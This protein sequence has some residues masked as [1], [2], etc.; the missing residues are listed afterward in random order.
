MSRKRKFE[1]GMAVTNILYVVKCIKDGDWIMLWDKPKHP[2]FIS[3]MPLFSILYL[4]DHRA[5]KVAIKK[6]ENNGT[7]SSNNPG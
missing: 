7:Q 1:S 5:F 6:G 2:R 4:L 3:Q